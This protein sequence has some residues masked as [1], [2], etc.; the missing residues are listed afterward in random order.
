MVNLLDIT[1]RQHLRI[2]GDGG[3]VVDRSTGNVVSDKGV[4]PLLC[5]FGEELLFQHGDERRA[6]AVAF[7]RL[8][9][10]WVGKQV[11]PANCAAKRFPTLRV[12]GGDGEVAVGSL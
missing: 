6:V 11:R 8:L 12:D 2:G 1:V 4:E 10:T 3:V 5:A 7:K 9:E